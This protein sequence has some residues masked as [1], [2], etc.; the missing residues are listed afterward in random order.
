MS[1]SPLIANRRSVRAF[2]PQPIEKDKVQAMLESARW[3][4]SCANN[5]PWRYVLVDKQAATR[6]ALEDALAKGNAWAKAAPLLVVVAAREGDDGFYN[7]VRYYLYDCGL[8]VMQFVLEAENQGLRAH[9][10]AGWDGEKLRSALVIPEDY[11]PIVV[12]A[13]GC[14][15]RLEDLEPDVQEKER[16]PRTRKELSEI[17]CQG[18]WEKPLS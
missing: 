3:A 17:A 14:E 4:P 9:Q 15:G 1:Q 8:S 6:P 5:Q 12:F 2:S 18:A 10:M 11:Q 16:K 7:G 13:V